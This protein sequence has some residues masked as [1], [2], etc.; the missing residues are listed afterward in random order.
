MKMDFP[1]PRKNVSVDDPAGRVD[2]VMDEMLK[3]LRVFNIIAHNLAHTSPT[4]G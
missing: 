2:K 1:K 3:T 4:D